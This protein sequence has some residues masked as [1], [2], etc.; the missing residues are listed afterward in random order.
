MAKT[1]HIVKLWLVLDTN[2]LVD[3]E[4][5]AQSASAVSTWSSC[6]DDSWDR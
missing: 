2:E 1:K 6:S 4:H 5:I 3:I